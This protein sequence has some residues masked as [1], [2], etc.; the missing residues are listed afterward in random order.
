MLHINIY[1]IYIKTKKLNLGNCF[2]FVIVI[3]G[4]SVT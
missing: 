3:S 2:F 4:K 1:K